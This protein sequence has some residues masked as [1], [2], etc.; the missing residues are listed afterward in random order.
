MLA[1]VRD[2]LWLILL[3][4]AVIGL[5]KVFTMPIRLLF[6]L[7]WNGIV[8]LVLLIVFNAV[9]GLI[10]VTVGINAVSCLVTGI[11]GIPGLGLLLLL[12]W[13]AFL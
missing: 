4:A 7:M 10:G 3:A 9:G 1:F 5:V 2:F 12:K 13:L 11:L 6:R 8:G